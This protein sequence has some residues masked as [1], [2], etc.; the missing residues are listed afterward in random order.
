MSKKKGAKGLNPVALAIKRE[1]DKRNMRN[2]G[3]FN[4]AQF[5]YKLPWSLRKRYL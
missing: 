3:L 4:S 2:P 5:D 1:K